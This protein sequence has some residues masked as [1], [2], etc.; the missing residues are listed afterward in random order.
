MAK[1]KMSKYVRTNTNIYIVIAETKNF[2]KF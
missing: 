1:E 2:T